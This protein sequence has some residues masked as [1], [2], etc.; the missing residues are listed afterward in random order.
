MSNRKQRVKVNKSS[1]NWMEIS[2]GVPQ[3]SVLGSVLF[4][5]YINDLSDLFRIHKCDIKL[6]ADDTKIHLVFKNVA[7]CNYLQDVLNI[8]TNWCDT[9]QLKIN[10][11]KCSVLHIG[12]NNPMHT[13]YIDNTSITTSD[14][15]ADL[16]FT[17]S[18][19]L[20]FTTHIHKTVGKAYKVINVLFKSFKSRNPVFMTKLYKMY[21]RPLLEYGS[22]VWNPINSTEIDLIERVQKYFSR[23]LLGNEWSYVKRLDLLGL[24]P[25][26][27]R[28][29]H[30]DLSLLYKIIYGLV[31][32]NFSNWFQFSHRNNSLFLLQ[33]RIVKQL[34][35]QLFCNRVLPC[36]ND[37]YRQNPRI[38]SS[39][40]MSFKTALNDS[41]IQLIMAKYTKGRDIRAS[42][43]PL[44]G[45][46]S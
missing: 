42:Q 39:C 38:M 33:N 23:R 13:Y 46:P 1:S 5:I 19:N 3:G 14:A 30:L 25:L 15:V 37:I 43:W 9:W 31:D 35:R 21:C 4:L 18:S 27:I 22:V 10:V 36:Y 7:E 17:I 24:Q 8:I 12:R 2:S 44:P 41:N 6:F 26:E 11:A 28:R 45:F 34:D 16:G 40:L 20:K 29:M 32:I